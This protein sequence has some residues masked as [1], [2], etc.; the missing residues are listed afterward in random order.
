MRPRSFVIG[1]PRRS[2]QDVRRRYKDVR[3]VERGRKRILPSQ[4]SH[5]VARFQFETGTD[6]EVACQASRYL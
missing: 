4:L 6:C 3:S 5:C 2:V 1:A